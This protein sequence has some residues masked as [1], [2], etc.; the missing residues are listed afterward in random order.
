MEANL[1]KY[2]AFVKTVETGS[3]TEAARKLNYSQ[4]GISR[5]IADLETEWKITLLERHKGGVRLTSDGSKM[6]P[7][8][9]SLCVEYSRL[10]MQLDDLNGLQSGL[11]RIG[12]F[13][14]AAQLWIPSM[15]KNFQEKFPNVDY[16][17]I[18]GDYSDI[19]E[20]ILDGTIDCGFLPLPVDPSLESIFI[21]R[22]QLVVV[23]PKDHP[24]ANLDTFPVAELANEP[25]MLL[26]KGNAQEVMRILNQFDLEPRI[27]FKTWDDY[28]IMAMVE[29]GLG[30]S[31]LTE[32]IMQRCPYDIVAKSL[33]T[34]VYRD[35]AL[36]FRNTETSSLA[37][38]RFIEYLPSV[39]AN[40]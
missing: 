34:P 8:A 40:A 39:Q 20:W 19:E 11:I 10:Q 23:M 21:E 32:Q 28:A 4:S 7:Y 14:S 13:S 6:Y 9:K 35:V 2:I 12:T 26:E 37:F 31:I 3:F 16:E 38:R 24:L 25:L 33:D 36:V 18:L 27:S 15:I 5:M 1:Q 30:V 17:L 22:N 29:Q